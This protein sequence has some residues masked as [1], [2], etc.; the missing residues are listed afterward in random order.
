MT[1]QVFREKEMLLNV[2]WQTRGRERERKRED[3]ERLTVMVQE[4]DCI[5]S[6]KRENEANWLSLVYWS[7]SSTGD[8]SVDCWCLDSILLSWLS[9]TSLLFHKEPRQGPWSSN[10]MAEMAYL[11]TENGFRWS[12]S[13]AG[14]F[15]LPITIGRKGDL[16][17][18]VVYL[19]GSADFFVISG[20][21]RNGL[22]TQDGKTILYLHIY[23]NLYAGKI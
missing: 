7:C 1:R 3:R 16:V 5:F 13:R 8:S 12:V 18:A 4:I 15:K 10:T 23:F 20:Y 22:K 2:M 11:S 14:H 21:R 19:G 17:I 9:K 6:I